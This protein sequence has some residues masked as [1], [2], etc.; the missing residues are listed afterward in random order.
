M[1]EIL[2][3]IP[4]RAGS[5]RVQDKNLR[6]LNGKPLVQYAMQAALDSKKLSKIVLSSD[7]QEILDCA[8]VYGDQII[9]IERPS[10]FATD[11]SPAIEYVQHV[12][13]YLKQ[14][15]NTQ[16][17][18]VAIIQPSSP[19]TKGYDIDNTIQLMLDYNAE[20]AVSVRE[21]PYDL[22]PAK[23]LVLEDNKVNSFLTESQIDQLK[24]ENH[25]FYARNGSVYVSN[26]NLIRTGRLLSQNCVAYIMPS[27]RSVDIN[28][29]MDLLF[30]EF[31]LQRSGT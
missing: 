24:N 31:L 5:K 29:E 23:Y 25:K 16:F 6:L 14:S 10:Q 28:D 30:A 3:I 13:T 9:A 17:D 11:D 15:G 2:G 7:S 12:L 4:A 26:I 21:V 20:C 8:K 18:H 22:R 1:P 27:D 19:L